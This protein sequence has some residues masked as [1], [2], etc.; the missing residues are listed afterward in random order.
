MMTDENPITMM[1][2]QRKDKKTFQP[3]RR[4]SIIVFS[5][6]AGARVRWRNVKT[7][8]PAMIKVEESIM[9]AIELPLTAII[10]PPIVVPRINIKL[11][12]I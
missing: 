11:E 4:S 8:S 10:H 6:A 12:V 9:S 5:V 3:C 1:T 2:I 7:I